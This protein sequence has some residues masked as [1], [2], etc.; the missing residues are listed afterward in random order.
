M[1][2]SSY[3]D[4]NK[5]FTDAWTTEAHRLASKGDKVPD[6]PGPGFL[7]SLAAWKNLCSAP[8]TD[9]AGKPVVCG[10]PLSI[11][12]DDENPYFCKGHARKLKSEV[13]N[14]ETVAQ[15]D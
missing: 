11:Y 9:E 12:G 15:Q 4:T 3:S 10:A 13:A 7:S 2:L 14:H 6:R 1:R 8:G 5:Q